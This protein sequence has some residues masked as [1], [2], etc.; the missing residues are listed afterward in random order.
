[1]K[2][3]LV[4]GAS[5]GIGRAT[6]PRLDGAGWKVFA[7]VRKEEDAAALAAEG[8]ERLEPLM[9]DVLDPEAIAAAAARV[10]A[11]PGGLDGLV[12]NAGAAVAGPLEAL[13][14]DDFRRQV[15]LNLTAQLA[16]TQAMLPA[17]RTA[18]GRV[19][20]ITSLGGRVALP[21]TGAYHAAK[22]GLEGLGDSLRQELA[23]WGI[24]V[25]IVEPG[26]IDT[27]IWSRGEEDADRVFADAPPRMRELYEATLERYRQ[28]IRDTAE[29]GIPPEKVA[30]R[31]EVA[32][33]AR[34]PR[35]RYLVGLDA[36]VMA[37]LKPLLPTPVFDRL[38]ARAMAFPKPPDAD[39]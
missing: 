39:R 2:T 26:S 29:R 1:M 5:S 31:I 38:I 9:L 4:T 25:V 10:A 20:L 13:P 24:K 36:Q 14:I 28:V 7:G 27:P 30:A 8:S 32:L 11:E 34:R 19:V 18:R 3:V 35:A 12:D 15:E 6:V 23:P 22:F 33:T 16:V 21:M 17:I 37:R